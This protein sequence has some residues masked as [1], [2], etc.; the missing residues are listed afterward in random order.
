MGNSEFDILTDP[1][2]KRVVN[3]LKACSQA[4]MPVDYRFKTVFNLV[5]VKSAVDKESAIYMI[6]QFSAFHPAHYIEPFL[7]GRHR[8]GGG[9]GR[10]HGAAAKQAS[11]AHFFNAF[12]DGFNEEPN[13]LIGMRC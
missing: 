8:I 6:G 13:I 11:C 2:N 9:T 7:C 4:F 1:L 10:W 12:L 3:D 5:P